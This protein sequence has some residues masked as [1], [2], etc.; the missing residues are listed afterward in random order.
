MGH[1]SIPLVNDYRFW[2]RYI[3]DLE[4][5]TPTPFLRLRHV[6]IILVA[7]HRPSRKYHTINCSPAITG[8]EHHYILQ[9]ILYNL[10]ILLAHYYK[11]LK[12][13]FCRTWPCTQGA[14]G[15]FN[16]IQIWTKSGPQPTGNVLTT[17]AAKV[18][19]LVSIYTQHLVDLRSPAMTEIPGGSP[20]V[21]RKSP[22]PE[23]SRSYLQM[24]KKFPRT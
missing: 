10:S 14:S 15:N 22:R 5:L 17:L 11:R 3:S 1:P 12:T 7:A 19:N 20:L 2:R 9:E 21:L 16:L 6:I 24:G 4:Y 23:Y 8:D 13:L 18:H